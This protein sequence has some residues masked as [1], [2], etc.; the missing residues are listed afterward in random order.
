MQRDLK[1][2]IRE[3]DVERATNI[4]MQLQQRMSGERV[5]DVLLSCIERLAWHEGDEPAAN[6]LLKNSASAFK[7]RFPGA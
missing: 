7:H 4:L 3:R 2:A 1:C 6:W 5:A